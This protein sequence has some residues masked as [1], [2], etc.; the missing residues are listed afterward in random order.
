MAIPAGLWP[1]LSARM[2]EALALSP[3][4]RRAWLAA[5]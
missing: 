1:E 4:E 2:D 3:E 5:L